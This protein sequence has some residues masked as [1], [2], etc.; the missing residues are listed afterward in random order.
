MALTYGVK[1][2]LLD[3][4]K[5]IIRNFMDLK[6]SFPKELAYIL[7]STKK[8]SNESER[9]DTPS[10]L[11]TLLAVREKKNIEKLYD[12]IGGLSKL[13]LVQDTFFFMMIVIWKIKHS[14]L[15][16]INIF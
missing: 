12:D 1:T 15:N 16:Q 4:K 14:L 2:I 6:G 10:N 11:E 7:D 13:T 3:Q 8:I 9:I 5:Q